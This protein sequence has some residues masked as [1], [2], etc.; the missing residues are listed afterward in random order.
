M[1]ERKHRNDRGPDDNQSADLSHSV[2]FKS[3]LLLRENL[4]L[5]Q[6]KCT[7]F[8]SKMSQSLRRRLPVLTFII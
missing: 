5:Q 8:D 2:G 6:V 3:S 7:R 4:T 1:Y